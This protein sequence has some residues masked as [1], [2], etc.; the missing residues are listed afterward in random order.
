MTTLSTNPDGDFTIDNVSFTSAAPTADMKTFGPG[1]NISGTNIT[2]VVPAGTALTNL[3]PTY[4][5]SYGATCPKGSGVPQ[6]FSLGPVHYL[7]TSSDSLVTNDYKVTVT[8]ASGLPVT[9][10][11]RVW[12]T[13]DAVDPSDP[14]QVRTSGSDVFVQKWL[15]RSGYGNLATNGAPDNQPLYIASGLNGK[16]VV[17]FV[18]RNNPNGTVNEGLG[19]KL[20]L[21]DLSAQ[22]PAAGSIYAVATI[23]TASLPSDGMYNLFGNRTNDERWV[24]G[25]WSE[26][27]PGS[28][29]GGRAN[30]PGQFGN[31][32]QSGSHLFALASSSTNYQLLVDGTL[33]GQTTG[34]YNSGADNDWTIGNRVSM[35]GLA[36]QLNGDIAELVIFNRILSPGE[37]AQM[38]Y[39]L[40]T[41]YG[42]ATPYQPAEIVGFGIPGADGV[43][44]QGSKTIA[45][46]VP[47]T[48]WGAS[49]LASLAPTVM[50]TSGTSRPAS[51]V[52]PTPNFAALNPATYTVID[53][54]TIPPT[55][56]TYIVTAIVTGPS[57]ERSISLFF[58]GVGY[59]WPSD[60]TG[61]NLLIAVPSSTAVT[62]LAPTYTV[63]QFAS[64]SPASG[65]VRDFTTPQTYVVTAED[66]TRQAYS[67]TVQKITTVASGYQGLVLATGPVS[68]WPLNETSGTT[69]FD[70]ASGVNNLTYGTML[71]LNQGGLRADG[72]PSVLFTN[73]VADADFTG[74]PYD[75]SLNPS[76]AFSV[77]FWIK[78]AN[79]NGQYLVSLQDRSLGGN[80]RWGYA[81]QRNN[82]GAGFNFTWGT[83]GPNS[84]T[85]NG[86]TTIVADQVY[87]VVATFDGATM[88]LYVNGNLDGSA[89][90]PTYEPATSSQPGFSIG[91][92][93]GNTGGQPAN[94]QDVALYGRA[95]TPQEI[96]THLQN[97]P[98]NL[99][100]GQSGGKVVLTWV[101]G[102][103]GLQAAPV[104]TGPYTNVPA[105]TSPY[106]TTPSAGSTFW[107]VKF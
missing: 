78:P 5:A 40:A 63:S 97:A 62:A 87:H 69:A 11:L 25:N 93:N 59:A 94:I 76:Q 38:G 104:V 34:D 83:P 6:D 41:K 80:Q 51:G 60:D 58:P 100:V 53:E 106:T 45:L 57:S 95:L 35:D 1:A 75:S 107:R 37:D 29:R 54:T 14:T 17:E 71:S 4:T 2:W 74:K 44:D 89:A 46:T 15:D 16:P 30:F 82:G 10:G 79:A 77:E 55:T 48:P 105:A 24:G 8:A 52:P 84:Q 98:S 18:Q 31:M 99:Q 68:Y 73:A 66:G 22:F 7:L 26:V 27:T 91:S 92:R 103:G 72:N 49:G 20:S 88:K 47:Y 43:I 33:I 50:L 13:A 42:V 39:H 12:L 67:V 19:S 70:L 28:F 101:P 90:V 81:I 86:V 21:G 96:Q 23:G 61:T 65:T 3:A 56:N 85:I 9:G 32:P 64:C 36:A 102:G